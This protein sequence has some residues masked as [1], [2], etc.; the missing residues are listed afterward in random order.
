MMHLAPEPQFHSSLQ[1]QGSPHVPGS[2]LSTDLKQVNCLSFD[3]NSARCKENDAFACM[4]IFYVILNNLKLPYAGKV[5]RA[6]SIG[7]TGGLGLFQVRGEEFLIL[8]REIVLI[9]T[10][11]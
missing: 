2:E 5:G 8:S 10:H 7:G 4:Y 11:D 6:I 9:R 3:S 1:H